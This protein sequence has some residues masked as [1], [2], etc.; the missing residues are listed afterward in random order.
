VA[1]AWAAASSLGTALSA[2]SIKLS[3]A[4]VRALPVPRAAWDVAVAALRAGDPYGCAAAMCDAAGVDREPL[5][6]WWATRAG[7]SP[8][9]AAA[10]G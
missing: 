4:Q 10:P 5:L 7:I 2:Q 1:T 9:E 8:P 6:R 3:A